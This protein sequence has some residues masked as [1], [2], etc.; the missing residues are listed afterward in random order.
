MFGRSAVVGERLL[1]EGHTGRICRFGGSVCL[2]ALLLGII[3]AIL[4]GT[5]LY[6]GTGISE[7]RIARNPDFSRFGTVVA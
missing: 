6:D 4:A 1:I 7:M 5:L 2:F 3:P